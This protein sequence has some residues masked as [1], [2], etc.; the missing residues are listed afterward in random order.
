MR[1]LSA[2]YILQF[3][4]EIIEVSE[5]PYFGS[6]SHFCFVE[7]WA[8]CVSVESLCDTPSIVFFFIFSSLFSVVVVV[9][10]V[11][12]VSLFRRKQAIQGNGLH[13][14][15]VW[16]MMC[17]VSSSIHVKYSRKWVVFTQD[18][19]LFTRQLPLHQI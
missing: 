8:H 2:T 15:I 14:A 9:V 17:A 1:L 12:V 3:T 16:F 4:L 7:I 19:G 11:V 6:N 18:D 13:P 5:H 10:V